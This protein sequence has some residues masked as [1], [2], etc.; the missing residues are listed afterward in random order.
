MTTGSNIAAA[1]Y[2][3]IQNKAESLLGTGSITRGYGQT[4]QSTDVFTGN[5]ITK[6]QWDALRFDVIN[7]R[8]HQDGVLPNIVQVNAGDPIVYGAANPNTNYDTLLETAIANR[9]RIANN[10]SVITSVNAATTSSAW[11]A[12]ATMT[13]TVTFSNATDARYFFNSGGKITISSTLTGGSATAQV[14]AWK[15]ILTSVGARSFGADTDPL[16]NYYTLTNSFQ[17]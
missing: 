3:S 6:A 2:V 14:N 17:T 13:T 10:Q 8:L 4:V 9:F 15:N 7:I 1:D 12:S 5:T 16:V 11:S